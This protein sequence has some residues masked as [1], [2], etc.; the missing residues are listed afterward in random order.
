MGNA[1]QVFPYVVP[2]P[3][4][5]QFRH[6][7][8]KGFSRGKVLLVAELG[9]AA[10]MILECQDFAQGAKPVPALVSEQQTLPLSTPT[11]PAEVSRPSIQERIVSEKSPQPTATVPPPAHPT[12]TSYQIDLMLP[13]MGVPSVR[14][15]CWPIIATHAQSRGVHQGDRFAIVI[16]GVLLGMFIA[17]RPRRLLLIQALHAKP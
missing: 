16:M 7:S 6:S 3:L 17:Q 14:R 8:Q 9:F 12:S 5:W 10:L 1:S 4:I 11:T 15:F 13:Y 2:C